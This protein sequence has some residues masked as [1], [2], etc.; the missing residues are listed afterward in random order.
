M[1]KIFNHQGMQIKSTCDPISPGRMPITK[2]MM[3]A[4]SG[5][6]VEKQKPYLLMVEEG[7]CGATMEIDKEASQKAR[8]RAT[9]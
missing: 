1:F 4:N 6:E 8:N 9:V 3:T 2:E 5:M 7:N